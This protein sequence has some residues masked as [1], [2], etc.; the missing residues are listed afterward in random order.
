MKHTRSI[1]N[2]MIRGNNTQNKK[3]GKSS[4]K[5]R[6]PHPQ[7]SEVGELGDLE[8]KSGKFVVSKLHE[9]K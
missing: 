4:G 5:L 9:P 2:S 3:S 1:V 8:R 6:K 7:L